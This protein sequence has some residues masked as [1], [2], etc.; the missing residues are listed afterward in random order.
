[1]KQQKED[2]V[3]FGKITNILMKM[4]PTV[5]EHDPDEHTELIIAAVSCGPKEYA[6]V[7]HKQFSH[8]LKLEKND[9]QPNI[10]CIQ[11]YDKI[12]NATIE[13]LGRVTAV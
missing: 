5:K 1:M 12:I 9:E 10:K 6:E 3:K 13:R 2:L 8:V 7:V 4:L 11:R